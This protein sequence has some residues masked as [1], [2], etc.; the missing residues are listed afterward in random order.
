MRIRARKPL[1]SGVPGCRDRE[2]LDGAGPSGRSVQPHDYR[3]V[4]SF[5]S[6]SEKRMSV[7]TS[8]WSIRLRFM[9]CA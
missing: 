3:R 6:S 4:A 9:H 7:Q 2:D 5:E 1:L 8:A